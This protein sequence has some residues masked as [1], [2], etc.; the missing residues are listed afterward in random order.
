MQ[1]LKNYKIIK[2]ISKRL[3]FCQHR[4][5]QYTDPQA[6]NELMYAPTTFSFIHVL[7]VVK[8]ILCLI[9][10][11]YL[12]GLQLQYLN[13]ATVKLLNFILLE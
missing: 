4:M 6:F 7:K 12:A 3:L 9:N 2:E 5:W 8:R 11:M 1:S 13:A 10:T